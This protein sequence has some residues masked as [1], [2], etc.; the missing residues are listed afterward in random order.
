MLKISFVFKYIFN[1]VFLC[2]QQITVPSSTNPDEKVRFKKL[3]LNLCQTEYQKDETTA[4]D[5][6]NMQKAI[7]AAESVR[8]AFIMNIQSASRI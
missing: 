4:T 8:Y 2:C 3:L 1:I 7:D 6:E 5:L